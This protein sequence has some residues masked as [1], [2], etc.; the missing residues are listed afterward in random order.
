[1]CVQ[2]VQCNHDLK[3]KWNRSFISQMQGLYPLIKIKI[4]DLI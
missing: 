4:L 3:T 1:M 2:I